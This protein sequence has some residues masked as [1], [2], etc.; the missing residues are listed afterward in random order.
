MIIN[1]NICRKENR[2]KKYQE[3]TAAELQAELAEVTGLYEELKGRGLSLNMARGK[4]GKAQL[5]MV[6]DIMDVLRS[7]SDF[8]CDGIDV[9]NYGNLEG[10]PSCNCSATSDRRRR[11]LQRAANLHPMWHE[12]KRRARLM[13]QKSANPRSV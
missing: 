7:D 9:R 4:P 8:M 6:S 2:M 10:L 3:M 5:D 1:I 13:L 11:M 12:N